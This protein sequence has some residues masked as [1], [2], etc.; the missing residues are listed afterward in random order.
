MTVVQFIVRYHTY[1]GLKVCRWSSSLST[2]IA[3]HSF[4][5]SASRSSLY[6]HFSSFLSLFCSVQVTRFKVFLERHSF[7]PLRFEV[8]SNAFTPTLPTQLKL[9]SCSH[10]PPFSLLWAPLVNLYRPIHL[11]KSCFTQSAIYPAQASVRI[12]FS[13]LAPSVNMFTSSSVQVA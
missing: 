13:P 9:S 2:F 7:T 1:E 11:G 3:R 4:H 5:H 10:S 6:S 12:P 8:S